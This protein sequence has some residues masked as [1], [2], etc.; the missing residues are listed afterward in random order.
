MEDKAARAWRNYLLSAVE[1]RDD[2]RK[3]RAEVSGGDLL[4]SSGRLI[5]EVGRQ[6]S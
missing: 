4:G 5:Y 6:C 1:G 3:A 2:E